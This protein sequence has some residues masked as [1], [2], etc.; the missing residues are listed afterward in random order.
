LKKD[1]TSTSVKFSVKK[2]ILC[3]VSTLEFLNV[4]YKKKKKKKKE[5]EEKEAS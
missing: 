3:P 4:F 2:L 5:E 1:Q